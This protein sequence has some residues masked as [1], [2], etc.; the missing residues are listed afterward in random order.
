MFSQRLTDHEFLERIAT[1]FAERSHST[2]NRDEC[3]RLKRLHKQ[4]LE[5]RTRVLEAYFNN[6]VDRKERDKRLKKMEA[7]IQFCER[8]LLQI[9]TDTYEIS[10]ELLANTLAPFQEW[11]FL[12][13]KDK[14]G[15]LQTLL[16]EI[17]IQNYGVTKLAWLVPETHRDEKNR[18]DRD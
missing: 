4:L 6:L 14:R 10:A 5:K 13:R 1:A 16:P 12:S 2:A 15:L 8:K 3:L 7:D 11:D 9:R 17:H 18:M